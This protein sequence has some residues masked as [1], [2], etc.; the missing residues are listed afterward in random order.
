MIEVQAPTRYLMR[1]VDRHGNERIFVRRHGRKIRIRAPIGTEQFYRE[2]VD[3]LAAL[4][5]KPPDRETVITAA[6]AGTLGWLAAKY[7]GSTEF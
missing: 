4:G 2:Y 5:D 1:D 7:F 6:A 3:G